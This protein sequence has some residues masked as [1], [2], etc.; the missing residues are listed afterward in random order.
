MPIES[1]NRDYNVDPATLK[2][3][4]AK[5]VDT[6]NYLPIPWSVQ[7]KQL[8]AFTPVPSFEALKSHARDVVGVKLIIGIDGSVERAQM[9]NVLPE[10]VFDQLAAVITQWRFRPTILNGRRTKVITSFEVQPAD[11][12][13]PGWASKDK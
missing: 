4:P 13:D 2:L 12:E 6:Q 10:D 1:S 11:L 8:I 7:K 5:A 3:S 9:S